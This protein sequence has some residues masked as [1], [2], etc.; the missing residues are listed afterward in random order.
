MSWLLSLFEASFSAA[1]HS[2]LSFVSLVEQRKGNAVVISGDDNILSLQERKMSFLKM[3]RRD[4]FHTANT[5]ELKPK[6]SLPGTKLNALHR[7]QGEA[8]GVVFFCNS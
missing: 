1:S 2:C 3:K 7:H 8:M 4:Q 5:V 6:P